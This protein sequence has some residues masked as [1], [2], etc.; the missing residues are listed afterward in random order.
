MGVVGALQLAGAAISAFGQYQQGQAEKSVANAN[1]L[2]YEKQAQNINEAKKITAGQYRTK[3]NVLRGQAVTNAARGGLKISGTTANSISQSITE[4]QMDN[5]YEQFNL[6]TKRQE[7]LSN[8][9]MQ[10]FQG[11]Q[12]AKAG[13][14]NAGVTALS[15][16]KDF[17]SKYWGGS[18]AQTW[19]N[20]QANKIKNGISWGKL[21][22]GHKIGQDKQGRVY[23]SYSSGLN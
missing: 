21:A 5:A 23:A 4:L 18:A 10:R 13:L 2:I 15:A 8:A 3:A 9:A 20:G 17:Y 6:Q 12:A 7:A 14:M 19:F 11:K 22:S 1:A 16:G